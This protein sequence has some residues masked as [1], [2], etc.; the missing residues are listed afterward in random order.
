MQSLVAF[1]CG[2]LRWQEA[3]VS[4]TASG[5]SLSYFPHQRVRVSAHCCCSLALEIKRDLLTQK[6]LNAQEERYDGGFHCQLARLRAAS[7]W[8]RQQQVLSRC[9]HVDVY[10]GLTRTAH[11]TPCAVAGL[12]P[13]S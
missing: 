9:G 1:L 10:R 6:K 4:V 2:L 7:C 8:T 3:S 13:L 12:G 11:I 5:V